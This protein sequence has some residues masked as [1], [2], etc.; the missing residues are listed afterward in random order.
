MK[1]Y[2]FKLLSIL[3]LL[4]FLEGCDGPPN[5]SIYTR[6]HPD[7]SCERTLIVKDEEI[8]DL[9]SKGFPISVDSTWTFIFKVDTV[10]KEECDTSM[11][12]LDTTFYYHK[13]FQSVEELNKEYAD[14]NNY[15]AQLNRSVK[16]EKKFRWFYTIYKYTETYGKLYEGEPLSNYV[17]EEEYSAM[18]SG[19]DSLPIFEG[20]DSLAIKQ[21]KDSIDDQYFRWLLKS[22]FTPYYNALNN[23]LRNS[24]N[25]NKYVESLESNK[26]KLLNSF[27]FFEA[28]YDTLYVIADSLINAGGDVL[29][30]RDK[31]D[32]VMLDVYDNYETWADAYFSYPL[33]Y[34]LN[35][36]G[37]LLVTN[38]DSIKGDTLQFIFA[39]D[40]FLTEDYEMIA[41]TRIVNK[42]S[43]YVSS[44]I[45][46]LALIA[47]L[48]GRRKSKT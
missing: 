28:G 27:D 29:A 6:V 41:E 46:L 35:M 21:K 26:D 23:Q 38:A 34:T 32:S 11:S 2:N 5:Y 3:I 37:E 40:D 15:Y 43:F 12:Y 17:S 45:I 20:M 42:W 47:I 24:Q 7:G 39:C 48:I 8:E 22:L 10:F 31:K 16:L 44:I 13:W 18:E 36:P 19:S 33:D 9:D 1:T 4:L 25:L 30:L 14:S